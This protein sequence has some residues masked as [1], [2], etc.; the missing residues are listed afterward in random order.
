MGAPT[1]YVPALYGPPGSPEIDRILDKIGY[2]L[3]DLP[4]YRRL[5]TKHDPLLFHMLYLTPPNDEHTFISPETGRD[6]HLSQFHIDACQRAL[7]WRGNLGFA[8]HRHFDVAPRGAGKSTLHFKANPLWALA[9]GHRRFMFACAY[10]DT[11]AARHLRNLRNL[12]TGNELLQRDYPELCTPR[13]S[14]DNEYHAE[15]GAVIMAYGIGSTN[16][17]ANVRGRPDLILVDDLEPAEGSVGY[18]AYQKSQLQSALV[19]GVFGMNPNAAVQM[20]GTVTM[21]G[22]MAHEAVWHAHGQEQDWIREQNIDVH[23]YSPIVLG[24]DGR[25]ESFWPAR[26]SLDELNRMRY[27][28]KDGGPTRDWLLNFQNNPRAAEDGL[29]APGDVTVVEDAPEGLDAGSGG[30][31]VVDAANRP[32]VTWRVLSIDPSVTDGKR[33]DYTGISTVGATIHGRAIIE[34]AIGI[35]GTPTDLKA[36]LSR[37]LR[38]NG[39]IS[40]VVVETT[41][42]GHWVLEAIVGICRE[43]EVRLW[44]VKPS[45]SKHSR[46]KRWVDLYQTGRCLHDGELPELTVQQNS[47]PRNEFD[48]VMDASLIGVE[49]VLGLTEGVRVL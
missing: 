18:S 26:Y 29:W 19:N 44:E 39:T 9:H 42:G 6:I 40:D 4:H 35:R 30:V 5:Y 33:S 49:K 20:C 38:E 2:G 11:Q 16:L 32:R 13:K 36:I 15:S 3:L 27:G 21:Y 17:G 34:D 47:Y 37:A 41:Q 45:L 48:D 23:Y 46:Y 24:A 25:E 14:T 31:T 28:A 43:F 8:Q 12:F 1:E 7:G 22:S 10:N